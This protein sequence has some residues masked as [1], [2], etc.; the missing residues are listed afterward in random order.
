MKVTLGDVLRRQVAPVKSQVPPGVP[1]P[2][3]ARRLHT[4]EERKEVILTVLGALFPG[5]DVKVRARN[6]ENRSLMAGYWVWSMTDLKH[7]FVSSRD[8]FA[9]GSG[10]DPKEYRGVVR[11]RTMRWTEFLKAYEKITGV[12]VAREEPAWWARR[13][14][15][16]IRR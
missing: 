12:R 5:Q 14:P 6:R 10:R 2:V 11:S 8:I 3:E 13:K 1:P 7:E 4:Y 15:M 9:R 16:R